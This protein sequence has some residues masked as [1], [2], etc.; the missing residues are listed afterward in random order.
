M[1]GVSHDGHLNY[2]HTLSHGMTSASAAPQSLCRSGHGGCRVLQYSVSFAPSRMT[3][4]AHCQHL[5]YGQEQH[6]SAD[7]KGSKIAGNSFQM[8]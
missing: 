5:H 8:A 1:A 6:W 4:H 7:L 2:K 3:A